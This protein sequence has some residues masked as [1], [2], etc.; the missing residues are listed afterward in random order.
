MPNVQ[1]STET[2]WWYIELQ[3]RRGSEPGQGALVWFPERELLDRRA[4]DPMPLR[5]VVLQLVEAARA[6]DLAGRLPEGRS[7]ALH[8][9]AD[10]AIEAILDEICGTPPWPRPWPWPGPPPWAYS[11][12]SEL[13]AVAYSLEAGELRDIV[14]NIAGKTLEKAEALR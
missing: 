3:V 5:T 7:A 2:P 8:K 13:S 14:L 9:S 12:A 6:K 1:R 4:S 10:S 11:L